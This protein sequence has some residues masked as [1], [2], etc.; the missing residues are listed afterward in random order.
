MDSRSSSDM[1]ERQLQ[2]SEE[3]MLDFTWFFF[4][5]FWIVCPFISIDTLPNDN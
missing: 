5:H 4:A 2:G 1:E 3:K